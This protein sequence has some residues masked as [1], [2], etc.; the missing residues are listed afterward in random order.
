MYIERRRATDNYS[1]CSKC[2]P[3]HKK[4]AD[5]SICQWPRRRFVGCMA[6]RV[7]IRCCLSCFRS[8]TSLIGVSLLQDAI[9]FVIHNKVQ[10]RQSDQLVLTSANQLRYMV[11]RANDVSANLLFCVSSLHKRWYSRH[12][13]VQ[14]KSYGVLLF[15][16]CFLFLIL[17]YRLLVSC[18]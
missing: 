12:D 16:F 5:H 13:G 8:L 9:D 14:C 15:F 6:V 2:C 3:H 11:S 18:K 4:E 1:R 10:I 7:A 17:L